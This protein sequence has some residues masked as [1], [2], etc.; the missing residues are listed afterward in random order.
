M[1]GNNFVL[2]FHSRFFP[3]LFLLFLL[4]LVLSNVSCKEKSDPKPTIRLERTTD[5]GERGNEEIGNIVFM[6]KGDV[7]IL[8]AESNPIPIQ[9]KITKV[10]SDHEIITKEKSSL[11]ILLFDGSII[12]VYQKTRLTVKS[13]LATSDDTEDSQLKLTSGKIF[14]KSTKLPKNRNI[15][16]ETATTVAGVRGTEFL[17]VQEEEDSRIIVGEGMVEAEKTDGTEK[18][19]VNPGQTVAYEEGN[20]NLRDMNEEEETEYRTESSSVSDLI[21]QGRADMDR[22]IQNFQEEKTR[23]LETIKE[24]KQED[25]E[26]LLEQK[27]KNKRSIQEQKRKDRDRMDTMKRDTQD[28]KKQIQDDTKSEMD[29]IKSGFKNQ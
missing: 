5:A 3:S 28:Q 24:Q 14:V 10:F 19:N 26:K 2:Y 21:S 29:R 16:V 9:A 20:L 7:S 25:K 8:D 17:V 18:T 13:L 23:I 12:R 1:S 27:E 22:I 15:R 6:V 4:F 11:D